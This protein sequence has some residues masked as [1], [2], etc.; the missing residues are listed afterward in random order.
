M[1]CP[2]C[3]KENS[4]EARFCRRCGASLCGPRVCPRCGHQ[5]PAD[6]DFCE[7]CGCQLTPEA[8]S[9]PGS[10]AQAEAASVPVSALGRAAPPRRSLMAAGTRRRFKGWH[11]T[12]LGE[13]WLRRLFTDKL[14]RMIT[15]FGLLAAALGA[16]GPS[17]ETSPP[18]SLGST[19]R[20]LFS[21]QDVADVGALRHAS[22]GADGSMVI[23]TAKGEVLWL[24][25][26][27]E[28]TR[29]MLLSRGADL[30]GVAVAGGGIVHVVDAARARVVTIAPDGRISGEVNLKGIGASGP[31]SLVLTASGEAFTAD[32]SQGRVLAL[33][34]A[35]GEV[36]REI[37]VGVLKRPVEVATAPD[38]SLYV[39]DIGLGKVLRFGRDGELRLS[40]P[41]AGARAIAIDRWG[42]L[43]LA[44]PE[45]Q[46]IEVRSTEGDL[47][48]TLVASATGFPQDLAAT[49]GDDVLV[50]GTAAVMR[51]G[52]INAGG[53][54]TALAFSTNRELMAIGL[55]L[56]VLS[57]LIGHWVSPRQS[58]ARLVRAG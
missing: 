38:G 29:R 1:L 52:V 41:S 27:G 49:G 26:S 47:L 19:T 8:T 24:S 53:P 12:G 9:T 37:G 51:V 42:R 11:S 40:L 18:A 44:S 50:T 20:L 55:T 2:R 46:G 31:N 13:P 25:P 22:I 57:W 7:E 30:R 33:D 15:V 5:N 36:R 16:L 54:S 28:V 48:Q 56:A 14:R 6:S 45:R 58:R 3:Q 21:G 39:L 43:Y 32:T 35:T 4:E 10:T 34:L 23:T 17:F